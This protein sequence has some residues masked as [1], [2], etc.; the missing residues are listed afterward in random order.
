MYKSLSVRAGLSG[1]LVNFFVATPNELCF[2]SMSNISV[3]MCW[4]TE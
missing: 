1:M 3:N 4:C 2:R